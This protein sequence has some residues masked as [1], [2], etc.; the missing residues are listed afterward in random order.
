MGRQGLGIERNYGTLYRDHRSRMAPGTWRH[1]SLPRGR[2]QSHVW[3]L[4]CRYFPILLRMLGLLL[5]WPGLGCPTVPDMRRLLCRREKLR[6]PGHEADAVPGCSGPH[7]RSKFHSKSDRC[8]GGQARPIA[9][10]EGACAERRVS[11]TNRM[12]QCR[13]LSGRSPVIFLPTQITLELGAQSSQPSFHC[14][15]ST[16]AITPG[17]AKR[18]TTA[19]SQEPPL[20][21]Q[22]KRQ[23]LYAAGNRG[24]SM[25]L[26]PLQA[27]IMPASRIASAPHPCVRQHTPSIHLTTRLPQRT[28]NPQGHFRQ[29]VW[30]HFWFER[31]G[32]DPWQQA[33]KLR[34][35]GLPSFAAN[36]G[37][38]DIW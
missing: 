10:N 22:G 4:W 37:R 16:L 29:V 34:M 32:V 15:F 19:C 25:E 21:P 28:Q 2:R 8:L 27:A 36:L 26:R 6:V 24:K 13:Q 30:V 3:L 17:E 9:W 23:R 14:R 33:T 18:K 31:G 5:R 7:T 11:R 1:H 35:A 20:L 38:L 12:S